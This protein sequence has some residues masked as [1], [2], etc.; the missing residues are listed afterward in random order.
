VGVPELRE[1]LQKGRLSLDYVDFLMPVSVRLVPAPTSGVEAEWLRNESSIQP[2][3]GTA[4]APGEPIR[5]DD[6]A[7][8]GSVWEAVE[9]GASVDRAIQIV[10]SFAQAAS[11]LADLQRDFIDEVL[12]APAI[13]RTGSPVRALEETAASRLRY[14][15]LGR[16]LARLLMERFVDEAVFRNL[17]QLTEFALSEVGL[18]TLES[19]QTV[20]FV[21]VSN[22]TRLSEEKGD[23]ESA[24]QAVALSQFLHK[25][26]SRHGGRMVKSLGDGA[27]VHASDPR[28]GLAIA[29]DAVALSESAGLWSLHAGVNSGAMVRRDGDYFGSA[30]NIAARIADEAGPGEVLVS[31]TTASQLDGSEFDFIPLG[32]KNL[33]HVRNPVALFRARRNAS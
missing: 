18:D 7:I 9:L 27:M 31:Q 5:Q 12:L 21:D 33:K 6:L 20:I 32:E 23:V 22:Y 14:R 3:L 2:L 17:V 15:E 29:M 1:A 25:L 8:L 28:Q 24:R 13:E 26:A 10:R 4:R 16:D 11:K 30:V 19:R